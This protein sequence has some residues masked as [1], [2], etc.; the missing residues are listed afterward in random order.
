MQQFKLDAAHRVKLY[1]LQLWSTFV[2]LILMNMQ[3]PTAGDSAK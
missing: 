2:E 1:V 3:K